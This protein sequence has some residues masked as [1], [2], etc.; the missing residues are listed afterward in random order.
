[1]SSDIRQIARGVIQE[2]LWEA[3]DDDSNELM[4]EER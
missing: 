1:M 3:T 4:P 2:R